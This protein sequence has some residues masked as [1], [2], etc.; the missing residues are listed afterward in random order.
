M[1]MVELR[2]CDVSVNSYLCCPTAVPT[3]TAACVYI[4]IEATSKW[5]IHT[6]GTAVNLTD[7]PYVQAQK[8]HHQP[9]MGGEGALATTL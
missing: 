6:L 2:V 3:R 5:R 4:K 8:W 9:S 1:M 7:I